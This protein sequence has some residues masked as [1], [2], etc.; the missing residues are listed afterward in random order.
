MISEPSRKWF[1]GAGYS[2]VQCRN[3]SLTSN[4]WMT[5]KVHLPS[6]RSF[7]NFVCGRKR[8]PSFLFTLAALQP[9]IIFTVLL[10]LPPAH[11]EFFVTGVRRHSAGRL[12]SSV[13]MCC[14]VGSVLWQGWALA[15][16][17]VVCTVASIRCALLAVPWGRVC[18]RDGD[19]SGWLNKASSFSVE[20][21][22]VRGAR[23][24]QTHS[25]APPSQVSV[26]LRQVNWLCTDSIL[27]PRPEKKGTLKLNLFMSR[28]TQPKS[29]VLAVKR[30]DV[31][32]PAS[33]K[34]SANSSPLLENLSSE[35]AS[36][37]V[38][39]LL[40]IG[41]LLAL[42]YQSP[43]LDIWDVGPR[44]YLFQSASE[45]YRTQVVSDVGVR[46]HKG[47][48]VFHAF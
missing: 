33:A 22:N 11:I 29:S 16:L 17:R 37:S 44:L 4:F 9:L 21:L 12:R 32:V 2:G 31:N 41:V 13:A 3:A 48:A 8:W 30:T 7:D 14:A 42:P 36:V 40:L 15:H 28:V 39:A 43:V 19:F 34:F 24:S 27:R 26:C 20:G 45:W 10:L 46:N 18:V 23:S 6:G 47:P 25:F 38:A 5:V 1:N 35:T